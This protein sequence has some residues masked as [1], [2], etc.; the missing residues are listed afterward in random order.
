MDRAC[1]LCAKCKLE[2]SQEDE[3]CPRLNSDCMSLSRDSKLVWEWQSSLSG[4]AKTMNSPKCSD[5]HSAHSMCLT[6][7][8]KILPLS[9]YDKETIVNKHNQLRAGVNPP[10]KDMQKL[11]WDNELAAIA[12]K[13]AAQCTMGHDENNNRAANG[14]P[15]VSIGQNMAFGQTSFM[16]AIDAWYSEVNHFQYGSGSQTG[17]AIG[18]YSQVVLAT[19]ARVGC[20]KVDCSGKMKYQMVYACNYATGQTPTQQKQPYCKTCTSKTG[21]LCDCRGMLC[22]NGGTFDISTCSCKCWSLFGGNQCEIIESKSALVRHRRAYKCSDYPS[23]HSMCLTDKGTNVPL[24][25]ADKKAIL[26][27]HNELRAGVSPPA[28]DMQILHWDD[29]LAAIAAKWGAQCQQGHDANSA[30][31]AN[32]CQGKVCFNGGTFDLSTCSC[33]CWPLYTGDQC[34]TKVCP[35]TK[36]DHPSCTDAENADSCTKYSNWAPE[37]CPFFCGLCPDSCSIKCENGGSVNSVPCTCLCPPGF[38][39]K[40]CETSD[41]PDPT[42]PAPPTTKEKTTQPTTTEDT[43]TTEPDQVDTTEPDVPDTTEPDQVDTTE[44]DVPDTTEPDQVDTTEP[45]EPDTTTTRATPRPG[46]DCFKGESLVCIAADV[47]PGYRIYVN[48]YNCPHISGACPVGCD[49]RQPEIC[50][51]YSSVNCDRYPSFNRVCPMKC[52]HCDK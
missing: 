24:S 18:H 7:R 25:A 12:A 8:G 41:N 20:A 39:G 44:P 5:Y 23:S 45:E 48:A 10:A 34:E 51:I 32:N 46:V 26:D 33:T 42:T 30:R 29:E 11:Y 40:R 14:F 22:L 37:Y 27:I 21:N 52:G 16:R 13:W 43:D 1:S 9:S 38:T 35:A 50:S 49:Y 4:G 31:R 3:V 19:A 15:G 17:E 2:S 28:S 36:T 6:D 47:F